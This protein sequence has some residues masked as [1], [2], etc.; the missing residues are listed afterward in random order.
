[1]KIRAVHLGKQFQ[2]KIKL[3]IQVVKAQYNDN[4]FESKLKFKNLD[5]IFY[6]NLKEYL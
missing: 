2:V 6:L 3:C 1:M 5:E 4:Q